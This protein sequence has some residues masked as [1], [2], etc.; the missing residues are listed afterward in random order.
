MPFFEDFIKKSPEERED[1]IETL[2]QSAINDLDDDATVTSITAT[3]NATNF[4]FQAEDFDDAEIDEDEQEIKVQHRW[5]ASGDQD[6]EKMN[7][8]DSVNGTATAVI[9]KN[10]KVTFEDVTAEKDEPDDEDQSNIED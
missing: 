3:T 2:V 1:E 9:D 6:D 7:W 5:S 4:V 8:G 10:G